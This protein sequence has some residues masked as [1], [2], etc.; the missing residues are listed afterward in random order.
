MADDDLQP[1]DKDRF[2]RR[3]IRELSG[4]L[5][6]IAGAEEANAFISLVGLR[7]GEWFAQTAAS[8]RGERPPSPET[9]ARACVAAKRRIQGGF[10]V[11]E[12]STEKIVL[13]NTAC[14]FG[15]AVTGRTSLCMMTSNIFGRI[16]AR[17]LGYAAVQL[18]ETIARGDA[19]CLVTIHLQPPARGA[20]P[21]EPAREYFGA[22]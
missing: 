11:I 17:E 19:G 18:H 1:L 10:H 7:M 16:V 6:E 3:L 8:E 4:Q 9:V 12:I 2:L 22:P 5:E 13:G 14:P 21:G 15:S 20:C